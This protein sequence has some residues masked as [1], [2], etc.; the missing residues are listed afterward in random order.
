MNFAGKRTAHPFF[1]MVDAGVVDKAS[2][3]CNV[4]HI[5]KNNLEARFVDPWRFVKMGAAAHSRPAVAKLLAMCPANSVVLRAPIRPYSDDVPV[6]QIM[7]SDCAG[8]VEIDAQL[9][10]ALPASDVLDAFPSSV[11]LFSRNPHCPSSLALPLSRSAGIPSLEFLTSITAC[12]SQMPD[13]TS[14]PNLR[15]LF[16]TLSSSKLTSKLTCSA[17][18]LPV[19]LA[20][21]APKLEDLKIIIQGGHVYAA[22]VIDAF[23]LDGLGRRGFGPRKPWESAPVPSAPGETAPIAKVCA[24][25]KRVS[26]PLADAIHWCRGIEAAVQEGSPLHS[27][28]FTFSSLCHIGEFELALDAIKTISSRGGGG[29]IGGSGDGGKKPLKLSTLVMCASGASAI[30]DGSRA[31]KDLPR[32]AIRSAIAPSGGPESVRAFFLVDSGVIEPQDGYEKRRAVTIDASG[33]IAVSDDVLRDAWDA[34]DPCPRVLLLADGVAE[35][36]R[37][38]AE[39]AD[40][41]AAADAD[42]VAA[43]GRKRCKCE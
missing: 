27:I 36:D 35:R 23:S 21:L 28:R 31:I 43:G 24:K 19:P 4:E 11:R 7:A 22:N 14:I 10:M 1:V 41:A 30:L 33:V 6:H 42:G 8:A 38:E 18:I 12:C 32:E 29:G 9:C 3:I 37:A 39:A 26:L 2:Q 16:L 34:V 25:L 5:R 13:V 40:V 15:R 17:D 20:V